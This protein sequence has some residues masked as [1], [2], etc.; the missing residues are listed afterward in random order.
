MK[1]I[2]ALLLAVVMCL[3][4]VACGNDAKDDQSE[5]N[6]D[7]GTSAPKEPTVKEE[8]EFVLC[9]EWKEV[10]SG[11]TIV[12]KEDGTYTSGDNEYSYT[13]NAEKKGVWLNGTKYNVIQQ[14][15]VYMLEFNEDE[16]YVGVDNY[17]AV[18]AIFVKNGEKEIA[19][20]GT[21]IKLGE[22]YRLKCGAYFTVDRVE[23]DKENTIFNVYL[24]CKNGNDEGCE[25]FGS[26][27]GNWTSLYL[28]CPFD[29]TTE[30]AYVDAQ[31]PKREVC[32]SFKS[33]RLTAEEI[34]THSED[35]YGY[36]RLYFSAGK[37]AFYINVDQFF[38]VK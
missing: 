15:G 2:I 17:E 14:Y 9:R 35:S 28:G 24:T 31:Y 36:F 21:I 38:D 16:Y 19:E 4:M 13:Y 34:K 5:K 37:E 33:K 18:H 27:R 8:T 6:N 10:K 29:L 3:S 23:L 30:N 25:E 7:K 22:Q 11:Y 32:L 12:L 1:R 26:V 20:S